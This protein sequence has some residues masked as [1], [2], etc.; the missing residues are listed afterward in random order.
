[1][2]H[3]QHVTRCFYLL[4]Y[5]RTN[6]LSEIKCSQEKNGILVC[7]NAVKNIIRQK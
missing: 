2:F 3:L 7:P 4:I 5:I 6:K 1:M